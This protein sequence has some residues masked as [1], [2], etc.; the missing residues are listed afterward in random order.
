MH[1]VARLLR[2]PVFGALVAVALA[3]GV[4]P[5]AFAASGAPSAETDASSTSVDRGGVA[6]VA[7]VPGDV[8]DFSFASFDARYGLG[9][10]AEG[11]STLTTVETFV[12]VF[13]E[14][15]QNRGIQRAIPLTYQGHPTQLSLTS[16]TD[17]SG[18]PREYESETDDENLIVTIRGS[19][20]VHGE[21]SYV[22]TYT[23]KD[24]TAFFSDTN[25]DEFYW[26]TNGTLWRQ[27]FAVHTTTTTVPA[28]LVGALTGSTAC[29]VGPEGSTTPCSIDRTD[30]GDSA[31]FTTRNENLTPGENVT[32]GIAFQPHTFTERDSSYLAAGSSWVQ[33]ISTI[34]AVAAAVFAVIYRIIGL[35]DAPGRPVIIPEYTPPPGADILIASAVMKKTPRAAAASFVD[36]AVRHNIQIVEQE[37]D[38]VFG[39]KTVY[40]LRLLTWQ[41]LNPSEIELARALFGPELAPGTWRELKK[42]DTSLSKSIYAVMQ[43]TKKR[44]LAEGYLNSG[45]RLAGSLLLIATIVLAAIG[46]VS[47]ALSLNDA[48][49][50]GLPMLFFVLGFIAV[51]VVGGAAFRNRLTAKGSELRDYIRGIEMYIDWAEEDRYKM[52]QS[53]EGALKTGVNAPDWGQVVKLYEKLLPY[54]VLLGLGAEW[55]KVLGTYYESL[56]NQPDWYGGG[57]GAFNAY[58]FASSIGALSSSA[59]SAYS[60]SSSS[61]SSGFSGGGG[62]SGGGGGGGGGGGV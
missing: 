4:A 18:T 3:L 57:S 27:P 25:D 46:F 34:L 9:I 41:G 43:A 1:K 59:A 23:Q 58:L 26:D 8:N 14:I 19:D 35:R 36:Y 10:D 20:Y 50:G 48:Y 39:S 33:L 52:L 44:A 51:F 56:G 53:P 49:G 5:A 29:F 37:Q 11:H 15:D 6:P 45:I 13:P 17:A 55:A 21:Q 7:A 28:S 2:V 47:G 42:N 16:V 54:A 60:G 24:V 12:A 38:A 31:I 40:W 32:I 30:Q 61:S 62:S 22:L